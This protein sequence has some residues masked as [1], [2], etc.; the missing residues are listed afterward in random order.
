M[1]LKQNSCNSGQKPRAR[2]KSPTFI[3]RSPSLQRGERRPIASIARGA[4]AALQPLL[5]MINVDS[6][7]SVSPNKVV[8][9]KQSVAPRSEK[10]KCLRETQKRVL[11][12]R[13][14]FSFSVSAR[15]Q[16]SVQLFFSLF[17][18]SVSFN[19]PFPYAE[20]LADK[21]R[22]LLS[23]SQSPWMLRLMNP[24]E[25]AV[26]GKLFVLLPL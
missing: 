3:P 6:G 25:Y 26:T 2:P 16:V 1:S 19:F 20:F 7:V 14:C 12:P 4:T 11:N 10:S 23:F 24:L 17:F 9:P 22:R 8:E 18:L 15:S 21:R 13:L 5:H